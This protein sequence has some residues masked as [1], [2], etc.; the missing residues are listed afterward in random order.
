M[1]PKRNIPIQGS[2]LVMVE[3]E[4]KE[5]LTL[6]HVLIYACAFYSQRIIIINQ[7]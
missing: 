6:P 7:L 3:E 4:I 2:I 5:Y 1:D